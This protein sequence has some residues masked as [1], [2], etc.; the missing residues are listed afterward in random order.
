[1]QKKIKKK[2]AEISCFKCNIDN[3]ITA[4]C[5]EFTILHKIN[6]VDE[7]INQIGTDK[8]INLG[9][10]DLYNNK[11]DKNN[12]YNKLSRNQVEKSIN[13]LLSNYL[14]R[15][16]ELQ[17]NENIN[18]KITS[19]YF[20]KIIEI[21][22]ENIPIEFVVQIDYYLKPQHLSELNVIT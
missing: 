12:K 10:I 3:N 11:M 4:A 15:I 19:L 20:Y 6:E 22:Y 16:R 17:N 13:V 7:K 8:M 5:P 1:M 9:K 2:S 21:E 14:T 18:I